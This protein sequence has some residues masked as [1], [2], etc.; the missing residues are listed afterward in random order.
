MN[1]AEQ[2]I[3][4][5]LPVTDTGR[6]RSFYQDKLGLPFIGD[7]AE[8][9]PQFGLAGGATLALIEKP[10]GAQGQ[11]T[12]LSFEVSG[13][14]AAIAQLSDAGV[15]F[16]DYDLPGL[17]TVAHICTLGSEKAA[18]FADPDGNILCLH[19]VTGRPS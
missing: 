15:E 14:E 17:R 13:I 5:I 19:E 3:T 6:A 11:H 4:T 10:P 2:P 12:A 8:G 7:D 1:L 16:A 9:K 18:W